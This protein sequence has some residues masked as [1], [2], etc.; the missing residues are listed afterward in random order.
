MKQKYN[1]SKGKCGAGV[2]VPKSKTRISIRI[3]DDILE[4]FREQ[5]DSVGGGNY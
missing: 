2:P 4:W 3:D 5:V 1:F